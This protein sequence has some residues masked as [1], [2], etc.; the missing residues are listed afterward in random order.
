MRQPWSCQQ[1]RQRARQGCA[2]WSQLLPAFI[3]SARTG[4]ITKP[5][6]H[7]CRRGQHGGQQQLLLLAA[8]LVQACAT[9]VH[10]VTPTHTRSKLSYGQCAPPSDHFRDLGRVIT[11]GA[12]MRKPSADYC[13]GACE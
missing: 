4:V 10:H 1:L 12:E 11:P 8:L 7:L 5:A 2:S 13:Q 9:Q 3:Q 6:L